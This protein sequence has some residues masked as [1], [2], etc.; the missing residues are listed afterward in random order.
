MIYCFF[1]A[2]NIFSLNVSDSTEIWQ[3]AIRAT[4]NSD[5]VTRKRKRKGRDFFFLSPEV[6]RLLGEKVLVLYVWEITLFFWKGYT[7]L[8]AFED[9]FS[10][11]YLCFPFWSFKF[12][13]ILLRSFRITLNN[14]YLGGYQFMHHDLVLWERWKT[15]L[16]GWPK[17][18]RKHRYKC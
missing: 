7:Y 9:V 15:L 1:V 4:K 5:Q 17:T 14:V 13:N 3:C 12:I 2:F 10:L 11:N 8:N 18:I 16:K 6:C